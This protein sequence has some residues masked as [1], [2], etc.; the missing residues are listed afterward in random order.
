M[1]KRTKKL[2]LNKELVSKLIINTGIINGGTGIFD[3]YLIT[4]PPPPPNTTDLTNCL[5]DTKDSI[6]Q[7]NDTKELDCVSF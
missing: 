5:A 6:P 7:K 1:K 3:S 4:C 2:S